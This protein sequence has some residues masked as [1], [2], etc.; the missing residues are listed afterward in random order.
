MLTVNKAALSGS[1]STPTVTYPTSLTATASESNTGDS[2]VAYR[3][4]CDNILVASQTGSAPSGS[5][6]FGAGNHDCVFNTTAGT[7][8]NYS[9]SASIATSTG[10][11]NLGTPVLR[12]YI[13]NTTANKTV[14]Y[15][16]T[17]ELRAN[18]TTTIT[19]PT[20]NFYKNNTLIGT[21]NASE[22][23][24]YG[25][26][27]YWLKYNT[28]GNAN[29]TSAE[30][31]SLVLT[32]NQATLIM[33]ISGNNVTYPTALNIIPSESNSGDADVNYTFWRNT[34][35]HNSVFGTAPSSDTERR[36][37]GWYVYR[38]NSSGGA[39]YTSNS[40]GVVWN[41]N[42]SMGTPVVN[43]F[44][45]GTAANMT[46]TYPDSIVNA[47][48]NSTTVITPPTYNFYYKLYDTGG[49]TSLGTGNTSTT[50][51][52]PA[53][54]H[55]L[56]YNTT[57]NANY[58]SA[59]NDSI[60]VI[61]NNGT[62]NLMTYIDNATANKTVTYGVTTELRANSTTT[63]TA[64]TFNFYRNNTLIGTGNASEYVQYGGGVYWLKYNTTGNANWT[65]AENS[66][67]VLTVSQNTT[68]PVDIYLINSTGAYKN[69]NITVN[70]GLSG[71]Q[72]TANATMVYSNSGTASLYEDNS[73]VANPRTTTLS[74][75][76]H[77]YKGNVTGNANYSSN[78]TGATFYMNVIDN[79]APLWQNQG[80]NDT[81]N[82]ITQGEGINLTAQGKDETALDWTWLSTNETGAWQNKTTYN[83]PMDMED[84]VDT[85]TWS[86]FTWQNS[87]VESGI[88]AWRIY[89]NDTSNNQNVTDIMTFR[90]TDNKPPQWGSNNTSPLSPTTYVNNQNYQFNITWT[91]GVNVSDVILEFNSINYSYQLGQVS[92]SGNIYYKTITDL[93]ANTSGYNYRWYANDTSN[94]WNSTSNLVYVINKAPCDIDLW[95]NSGTIDADNSIT[96][97]TQANATATI[98]NSQSF[99][100]LRNGT[101]VSLGTGTL[102]N[103]LTLGAGIY[104]Y[105]S[106]YDATANYSSCR[107][108]SILTV[109]DAGQSFA[110]CTGTD[111]SP[112]NK[113]DVN[114]ITVSVRAPS[115]TISGP[116]IMSWQSNDTSTCTA[117]SH[118]T[119][120][121]TYSLGYTYCPVEG[122][123]TASLNASALGSSYVWEYSGY[124]VSISGNP[125]YTVNYDTDSN[126]CGC[127]GGRWNSSAV[128]YE[129]GTT[130]SCCEDDSGEYNRTRVCTSGCTSDSTDWACCNANTKCVYSSTC[131]ADTACYDS[132][133]L[134]IKCNAGSWIDHCSNGVKD[135]DE[136][137]VDCGGSCDKC[138]TVLNLLIDDSASD[139][140][141]TYTTQTN[142]TGYETNTGD[143]DVTYSLYRNTSTSSTLIGSGSNV[144]D[145]LTLGAGTYYYVYNTSGG[146]NYT[147][148]SLTRTLTVNKAPTSIK[149]YLNDTEWTSDQTKEYPNATKVNATIN[150][151]N[152]QASVVLEKN[153]SGISNPEEISNAVGIYNYTGYYVATENYTGSSV[154]RILT[155]QDTIVPVVSLVSPADNAETAD[156]TPDFTFSVTDA[157]DNS[158]NCIL[159]VDDTNKGSN[160]STPTGQDVTITT[161]TLSEGTLSWY[162]NCTDDSGNT[163]KSATRT[164][165]L[166]TTSPTWQNQG[167]SLNQITKGQVVVLYAQGKDTNKLDWAILETNETGS[168]QNKTTYSSPM[169]MEDAVNTWTW[170]N[171]TWQNTSTTKRTIVGWRIYY[172]DTAGKENVTGTFNFS[173]TNS[174]PTI[175]NLKEHPTDPGTYVAGQNYQ[176]NI[177]INDVDGTGDLSTVILEWD[178]TNETITSYAT[179]NST[180]REYYTTKTD[181]AVGTYNYKWFV[182]DT[183]NAWASTS[184]SYTVSAPEIIITLNETEVWW[185]DPIN[186]SLVATVDGNPIENGN[187]N[188]TLNSSAGVVCSEDSATD[189]GGGYSC[190]FTA[191]NSVGNYNVTV[192]VYNPA[193]G[194][195]YTNSTLLTVKI[196]FGGSTTQKSGAQS[197]G[198]YDVPMVIVNPDGSIKKVV[199]NVC[200]WK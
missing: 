192:D 179:T 73:T 71:S 198:C 139:K 141:V 66:S 8:A 136:H 104:N 129:S 119:E 148:V 127:K 86:N 43:V 199:V 84:A 29:W 118:T 9:S 89:Y 142:A 188:I 36:G 135:C 147:S 16:V 77:S 145:V 154:T 185:G 181:L 140:T 21:G 27:V 190:T 91:D 81:D 80:T 47:S 26:G 122:A 134:H 174:A 144:Q 170:S 157:G 106:Y 56:I 40:T 114:N 30:N 52:F 23:I 10:T 169:D 14:T 4:Y 101:L 82:T 102:S 137:D 103:I 177:T 25:V 11:V 191:P 55:R 67:L 146:A 17:T 161:S 162:I 31:S 98:N 7:F 163:G 173:V 158:L 107:E 120:S 155:I 175:G 83:S 183:S 33:S 132:G 115:G 156:T 90:I 37:A 19:A 126:W 65:S 5:L 182:N 130:P 3:I 186:A 32:V 100:L 48:A 68:N 116:H 88:I 121:W 113:C 59:Q 28:T 97:P 51:R 95:L 109:N 46:R 133:G 63:I 117:A 44:T 159:Y 38:L 166:D 123:Y 54:T 64:P 75:G 193:T 79:T 18:S 110:D 167:Q 34:T 200:V 108:E 20:F 58:S 85:W 184:N 176:F 93:T 165:L 41:I 12:T 13:D 197:V 60:F 22:Y 153:T 105:T 194:K 143:D 164:L 78:A 150:V 138:T 152:L 172:N 187:V 6:Q 15:G 96:Y 87:S 61:V 35:L 112:C 50:F 76:T 49:G 125:I 99:T 160:S 92:K 128:D 149:L 111:V 180:A 2:D 53:G 94:N 171:F 131:Y 124:G 69:Q 70:Y 24:V 178:G 39:N 42:V 196:T 195:T 62:V 74:I 72:T 151:S 189:A 45:N 1:L 57:G 168:W